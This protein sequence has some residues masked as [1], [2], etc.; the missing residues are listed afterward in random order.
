LLLN[1]LYTIQS[2]S[3]KDKTIQTTVLLREDHP[4]FKGHFPGQPVLPGVCMLEMIAEIAGSHLKQ[5]FRIL[6]AP[7]IKFLNM[8]DPGK[9]PLILFE[10]NYE[11]ASGKIPVTGRI[12]SGSRVFMK[13]Q[14][15]LESALTTENRPL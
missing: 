15:T 6:D 9:D 14:M 4:I 7:L 8:I 1:N 12:S 3:E 2:L 13:F 11:I 10:I 5:R